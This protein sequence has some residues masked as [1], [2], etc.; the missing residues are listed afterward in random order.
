MTSHKAIAFGLATI[1]DASGVHS[2]K[3]DQ[4]LKQVAAGLSKEESP[5][6]AAFAVMVYGHK[7]DI[8]G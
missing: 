3:W 7:R 1:L 2:G 8:S 5:S 4:A 6:N